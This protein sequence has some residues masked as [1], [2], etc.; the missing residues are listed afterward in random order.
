M[1]WDDCTTRRCS[2]SA[3]GA[4]VVVAETNWN[5]NFWRRFVLMLSSSRW[6]R[7][8]CVIRSR[9]EKRV[10]M[11]PSFS[12][13]W[14]SSEED[15]IFIFA[16]TLWSS[17]MQVYLN[18]NGTWLLWKIFIQQDTPQRIANLRKETNDGFRRILT[19]YSLMTLQFNW[20]LSSSNLQINNTK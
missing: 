5:E 13:S 10:V 18:W 19:S 15:L 1:P 7:T 17:I 4:S 11:L 20:K 16:S 6:E 12:Y 14:T 2:V 3:W 8:I 9:L